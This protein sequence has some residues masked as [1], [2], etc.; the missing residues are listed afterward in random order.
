MQDLRKQPGDRE[1][2][3]ELVKKM[4]QEQQQEMRSILTK[5]QVEA[6]RNYQKEK[7]SE[8]KERRKKTPA[9]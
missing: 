1:E 4:R 8:M 5:D 6:Y 3:R 2:K 7:R 9:Q